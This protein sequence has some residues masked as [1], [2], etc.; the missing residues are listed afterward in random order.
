MAHSVY[1]ND[2]KELLKSYQNELWDLTLMSGT[3]DDFRFRD[4]IWQ[5]LHKYPLGDEEWA[6]KIETTNPSSC[7]D[8]NTSRKSPE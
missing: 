6:N 8:R 2:A 1:P 5:G 7:M 4:Q 3:S